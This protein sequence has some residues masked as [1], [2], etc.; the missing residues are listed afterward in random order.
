VQLAASWLAK[1]EPK[2]VEDRVWKLQGLAWAGGKDKPG[3]RKAL[4][5][6]ASL[7]RADGGW[8][9]TAARPS[10]A[11]E[12]GHALVALHTAG[13]PVSDPIYTRGVEFL[14]STQME[15]GS[16][17]VKTRA[18]ALQPYFETGFPHGVDQSVSAAGTS[19]A[20][21]ALTLASANGSVSTT[22]AGPPE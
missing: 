20:T 11:F 12:T 21:M 5:D 22:L 6:I 2:S 16:W 19:W 14:L 3:I 15:D 13:M 8:A 10:D 9:Q 4:S 1:A 7:Q 18:L 17:H